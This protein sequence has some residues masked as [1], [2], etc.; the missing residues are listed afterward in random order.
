MEQIKT[1]I[2]T[3]LLLA[4]IGINFQQLSYMVDNNKAM[5]QLEK[6]VELNANS[7]QFD[8]GAYWGYK[9]IELY[10][11]NKQQPTVN[12]VVLQAKAMHSAALLESIRTAIAKANTPEE[13]VVEELKVPEKK[14]WWSRK[15]KTAETK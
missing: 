3:V 2:M 4:L 10:L 13:T 5:Q 11:Q 1:W 8:V 9:A 7:G 12:D 6:R 14:H 15:K